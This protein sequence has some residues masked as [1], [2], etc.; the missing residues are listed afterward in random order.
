MVVSSCLQFDVPA[1]CVG[2]SAPLD[3]V[4][5]LIVI[6]GLLPLRE[7]GVHTLI[8]AQEPVHAHNG[9][10]GQDAAKDKKEKPIRTRRSLEGW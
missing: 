9:L 7:E 6:H 4:L 2:N 3:P 5:G 10:E 1:L 8:S